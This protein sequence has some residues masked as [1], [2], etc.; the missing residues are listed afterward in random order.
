MLPAAE[1]KN[2]RAVYV[3][4]DTE[5]VR[6]LQR[7]IAVYRPVFGYMSKDKLCLRFRQHM[8]KYCQLRI[9]LQVM[10]HI[11]GKAILDMGPSAMGLVQEVL[12]HKRIETTMSYYVQVCK[13]VA[14]KNY[15]QLFYQYERRVMT[16]VSF[17][18]DRQ[19]LET[20]FYGVR[21]MT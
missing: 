2:L 1:L 16:Q 18:I 6:M 12:G 10:R 21:Q 13:V 11:A 15:L 20:P 7:Y 5:T 14:Q 3:S 17:R 8:W 19:F 4:I 9:D